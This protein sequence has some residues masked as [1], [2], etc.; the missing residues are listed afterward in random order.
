MK[1]PISLCPILWRHLMLH[2][3]RCLLPAL[4]LAGGVARAGDADQVRATLLQFGQGLQA[5]DAGRVRALL[6]PDLAV[7]VT[8][9][10]LDSAPTVTFGRDDF[11]QT[12]T[13]LWRFS[14]QE[15]IGI[16]LRD[17][18][19][20]AGGG[21]LATAAVSEHLQV[22][23]EVLR[24]ESELTCSLRQAGNRYVIERMVMKTRQP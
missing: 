11:L 3:L 18:R 15:R 21:W 10:D 9:V 22:L 2:L 16:A 4:L 14:S 23:G 5:R 1:R 13:S 19:P 24:R 17:L 20:Q 6:A 12:Y 8:M 7:T